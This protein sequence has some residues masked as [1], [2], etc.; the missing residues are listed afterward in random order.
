MPYGN[1]YRRYGG[2]RNGGY[3]RGNRQY[4]SGNARSNGNRV[5]YRKKAGNFNYWDVGDKLWNDVKR[6]KSL[7]NTE[8]KSIDL[9][10]TGVITTTA[11]ITLLNGLVKGDDFDNRDGRVVRLKSIQYHIE[12]V[13]NTT[14][15]ND[16]LRIMI[17]IDKQPNEINM[18]IADLIDATNM[19]SF[20]NLDQRKRFVILKD[21]VLD[22][23]IGRGTIAR[24]SWYKKFDMK[25]T[26]DDSDAGT[27]VDITTNALYL[28]LFSTEASNGPSVARTTRI[29][30]IDN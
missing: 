8:F 3:K 21:T 15:I 9:A 2:Y 6:L 12:A 27:I 16:S 14:P 4:N 23:S 7:I 20:R 22:M 28:V 17:V 26:Y 18:V 13:M 29:R 24:D 25:T 10:T 19:T 30:Y 1:G 11:S 5:S